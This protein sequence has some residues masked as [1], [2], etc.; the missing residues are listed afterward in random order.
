MELGRKKGLSYKDQ[1]KTRKLAEFD[2]ELPKESGDDGTLVAS[3]TCCHDVG[4][5][6]GTKNFEAAHIYTREETA[7]FNKEKAKLHEYFKKLKVGMIDWSDVPVHYQVLLSKYYGLE[8]EN[9][10]KKERN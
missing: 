8:E 1:M 4:E 10:G 9:D 6:Q 5:E 2:N 3:S 7:S